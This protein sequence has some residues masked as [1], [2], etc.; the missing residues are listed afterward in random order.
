MPHGQTHGRGWEV[1]WL[2]LLIFLF[3]CAGIAIGRLPELRID[4]TGLALVGATAMVVVGS[5][6]FEAAVAAIDF[7]TI[8][9]FSGR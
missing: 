1:R 9:V 4:R 2:T 5:L 7:P 3:A 8:G 6:S